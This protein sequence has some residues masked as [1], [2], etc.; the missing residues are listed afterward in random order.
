VCFQCFRRPRRRRQKTQE[1]TRSSINYMRWGSAAVPALARMLQSSLQES[2][3]DLKQTIIWIL[4]DLSAERV[5]HDLSRHKRDDISA[6]LPAL[7]LALD[8]PTVRGA[9]AGVVGAI[10]PEAA[11]AVPKLVALL[12]DGSAGEQGGACNGLKRIEPL[13]ALRHA[14]SDPNPDKN[15]FAQRAIVRIETKCFGATELAAD[16]SEQIAWVSAGAFPPACQLPPY[17]DTPPAY[18]AFA[19]PYL[20]ISLGP[21]KHLLAGMCNFKAHPNSTHPWLLTDED[22]YGTHGTV[23]LVEKQLA[24]I[25]K[26][27]NF[28]VSPD[29]K[30]LHMAWQQ[31]QT[32]GDSPADL[33]LCL[34]PDGRCQ[35]IPATPSTPIT[36]L[37]DCERFA[38]F[39]SQSTPS[40][41]PYG[42]LSVRG[43]GAWY[44]CRSK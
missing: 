25:A 11:E 35:R 44:E 2:D 18:K 9:A 17:G 13:P 1:D 24:A 32:G 7:I 43:A 8:D 29:G 42:R 6:A 15:Q 31:F 28:D 27:I 34:Q 26:G 3:V 37:F 21:A 39:L 41:N 16:A 19:Q 20:G 14:L 4:S 30:P 23:A 33:F 10:G 12:G 22:Y 38:A 40:S 36:S 5:F